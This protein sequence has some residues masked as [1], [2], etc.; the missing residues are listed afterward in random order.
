MAL[1][2]SAVA[3]PVALALGGVDYVLSRNEL[4][5]LIPILRVCSAGMAGLRPRIG[6]LGL[7]LASVALGL[8][9]TGY[10]AFDTFLQ[11]DDCRSAGSELGPAGTA[12]VVSPGYETMPLSIYAPGL[13]RA[14]MGTH[15][16]E[17]DVI[18]QA[19]PPVFGT[20]RPLRGFTLVQVIRSPSDE[21][22]RY[23]SGLPPS[24]SLA[25]MQ[26]VALE[27]GAAGLMVRR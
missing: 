4:P 25:A 9:V 19:R 23:R 11:R 22:V 17:V 15:V 12:V 7:T 18:G 5:V 24:V 2:V 20:P 8:V 6:G 26:G 3:V 10:Y 21:L 1:A 27:A 16:R 13:R 14:A